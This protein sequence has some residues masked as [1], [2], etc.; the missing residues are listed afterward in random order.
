LQQTERLFDT[1]AAI[2][3]VWRGPEWEKEMLIKADAAGANETENIRYTWVLLR[4]DPSK[5]KIEPLGEDASRARLIINWHDRRPIAPRIKRQSDRV[6]IGVFI[7]T[8]T[9]DSAPA[10]ISIS[11]PTHQQRIYAQSPAGE[12]RLQEVDYDA[13]ASNRA[14]DPLLHWSAPWRD[15]FE[16]GNGQSGGW[17]RSYNTGQ[18]NVRFS[19]DGRAENGQYTIYQLKRNSDGNTIL[20]TL[21]EEAAK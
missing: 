6:D 19:A 7:S 8:P 16:D 18:P 17:I 5:V 2:A 3:R 11:F 1:P 9:M 10:F 20:T 15:R 13:L 12:M 14:Y 21:K 4:G